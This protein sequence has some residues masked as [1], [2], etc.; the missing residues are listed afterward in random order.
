MSASAGQNMIEDGLLFCVDA[1]VP[2]SYAGSGTIWYDL[3]EDNDFTLTN[4]SYIENPVGAI[5]LTYSP[6]A[7]MNCQNNWGN[8][9]FDVANGFTLSLWVSA[10][11]Y[12]TSQG[13]WPFYCES[14]LNQGF[15]S[16]V[17]SNGTLGFW[18][19]Q[20]GGTMSMSSSAGAFSFDG[21]K[22]MLTYT[23]QGTTGSI[24]H[25]DQL[26]IS[27]TGTIVDPTARTLQHSS[28]INGSAWAA[29]THKIMGYNRPLNLAE[30]SQN[31]HATKS[32]YQR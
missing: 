32:K 8:I 12:T 17:T 5:N 26:M 23:Y 6:H 21:S 2:Q 22:Q 19:T 9:G 16:R 30:I 4:C 24:Y 1:D 13:G 7:R 18:S 20:S 10:T 11:G 29:E 27:A 31:Y 15:R 14:Y 28:Y 25:N 3:I